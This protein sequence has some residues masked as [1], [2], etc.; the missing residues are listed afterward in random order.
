MADRRHLK[1]WRDLWQHRARSLLVVVAVALG[2]AA[3]GTILNAWALVERATDEGYRASLPV[4]AAVR[5]PVMSLD[6]AHSPQ[7]SAV[8][9]RPSAWRCRARASR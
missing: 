4:S 7:A 9:G 2:L 8:P 1:S 3:A 6:V 5:S